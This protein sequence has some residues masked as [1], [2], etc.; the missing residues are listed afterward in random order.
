LPRRFSE[1]KGSYKN[2]PLKSGWLNSLC[3]EE[4]TRYLQNIPMKVVQSMFQTELSLDE[5]KIVVK[6][7]NTIFEIS[8]I[9][10][11]IIF[12]AG[13]EEEQAF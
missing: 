9:F 12:D 1:L 3:W 7:Y 6:K 2:Q 11:Y 8:A 10:L 5:L 4:I 13:A